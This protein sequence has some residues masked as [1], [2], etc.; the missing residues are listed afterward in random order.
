VTVLA[1]MRAPTKG[2][3]EE[4][5]T[6]DDVLDNITLYWVTNTGVSSARSYWD[7]KPR[8]SAPRSSPSRLRSPS[9]PARSTNRLGAGR[10]AVIRTCPA[11]TRWTRAATPRR[12]K[13]RCF[14]RRRCARRSSRCASSASRGDDESPYHS[15]ASI[16]PISRT[17]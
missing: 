14:S 17:R 5:L 10:S 11:S 13:S 6:R 8:T 3:P 7:N 1:A 9:S 15:M 12:G 4:P 16:W 2:Q